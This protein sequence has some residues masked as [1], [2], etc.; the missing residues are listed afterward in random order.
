MIF[1]FGEASAIC[2]SNINKWC[3]IH[4]S[5]GGLEIPEEQPFFSRIW[6]VE[7]K[8]SPRLDSKWFFFSLFGFLRSLGKIKKKKKKQRK[9]DRLWKKIINHFSRR[10]IFQPSSHPLSPGGVVP[11]SLIARPI[12]ICHFPHFRDILRVSQQ[13]NFLLT[14]FEGWITGWR[15]RRKR[16]KMLDGEVSRF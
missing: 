5:N 13:W 8:R 9:E 16:N 15:R 7:F 1:S 12:L 4:Y 14:F 3:C 11:Q 10:C 2:K 6:V